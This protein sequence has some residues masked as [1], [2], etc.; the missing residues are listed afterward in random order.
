M[1][2]ERTK[3]EEEGENEESRNGTEGRREEGIEK[4][5]AETETRDEKETG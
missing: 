5:K 1:E 3:G 2:G 4:G